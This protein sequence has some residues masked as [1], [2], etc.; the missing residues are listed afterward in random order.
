M[1]S[2]VGISYSFNHYYATPAYFLLGLLLYFNSNDNII[3]TYETKDRLTTHYEYIIP[4]CIK[5][6]N[7]FILKMDEFRKYFKELF[8]YCIGYK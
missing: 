4:S 6:K 8:V 5:D 2:G 1:E 7:A 3:E